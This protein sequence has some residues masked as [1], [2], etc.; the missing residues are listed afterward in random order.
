MDLIG[1]EGPSEF[2]HSCTTLVSFL[3]GGSISSSLLRARHRRHGHDDP[4]GPGDRHPG[5]C[6]Q[7]DDPGVH[8]D[9]LELR[10]QINRDQGG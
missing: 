4:S 3:R 8:A 1:S 2:P 9:H 5:H 7:G 6:S 10:A